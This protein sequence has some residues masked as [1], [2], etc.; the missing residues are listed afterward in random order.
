MRLGVFPFLWQGDFYPGF[1]GYSIR[2]RYRFGSSKQDPVLCALPA[3]GPLQYREVIFDSGP[4]GSHFHSGR[5]DDVDRVVGI[6]IY[7]SQ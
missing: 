7:Q 4:E 3:L 2:N 1:I 5:D 6:G